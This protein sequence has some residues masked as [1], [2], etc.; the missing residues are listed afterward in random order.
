MT[1]KNISAEAKWIEETCGIKLSHIVDLKEEGLREE[2]YDI[3]STEN[4]L[5]LVVMHHGDEQPKFIITYGMTQI[6]CPGMHT[7]E[8]IEEILNL[9]REFPLP[10]SSITEETIQSTMFHS[11]SFISEFIARMESNH[12]EEVHGRRG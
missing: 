9:Q 5:M 7:S 6:P 4:N 8:Q 11:N 2:V 1:G 10:L 3:A 12:S